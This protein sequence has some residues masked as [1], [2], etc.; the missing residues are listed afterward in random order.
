MPSEGEKFE[1][2]IRRVARAIWNLSPGDGGSEYVGPPNVPTAERQ[3]TDIVGRSVPKTVYLV[4]CTKEKRMQ[5]V[6]DDVEKLVAVRE[7][8]NTQEKVAVQAW[9]VTE[10]EPTGHQRDVGARANVL[11]ESADEFTRRLVDAEGYFA[12]RRTYPFGSAT[13]AFHDDSTTV[14]DDEYVHPTIRDGRRKSHG[15]EQIGRLIESGGVAVLTADFGAGK[16][17]TLR[18]VYRWL[19]DRF[20]NPATAY[21]ARMPIAINLRDHARQEHTDDVLRQHARRIGYP[22]PE[23]LVWAWKHGMA[24]LLLDGFDELPAIPGVD[25]TPAARRHARWE[26]IKIVRDFVRESRT[27][28]GLLLTGRGQY[29][30]TAKERKDACGLK[31]SD[32]ILEL[33]P[34]S[35][36]QVRRYLEKRKLTGDLPDWLP[37]TPLFLSYLVSRDMMPE[38]VAMRGRVNPEAAWDEMLDKLSARE[39]QPAHHFKPEDIRRLLERLAGRGRAAAGG[40]GTVGKADLDQA[41]QAVFGWVKPGDARAV[42]LLQR[43]PGLTHARVAASDTGEAEDDA[44]DRR[45]FVDPFLQDALRGSDLAYFI[46]SPYLP[47]LPDGPAADHRPVNQ[48]LPLFAAQMAAYRVVAMGVAAAGHGQAAKRAAHHYRDPIL[49]ADCLV[50]AALRADVDEFDCDGLT[51]QGGEID[52]CDMSDVRLCHFTLREGVVNNLR[53]A[54]EPPD[55]IRIENCL[56]LKIDG[57]TSRAGLPAWVSSD[58][59]VEAFDSVA[60]A[61]AMLDQNLDPNVRVGLT[62]LKKLYKQRG[63]GRREG[64]LKRGMSLDLRARVDR[65][66]GVLESEGVAYRSK[67]HGAALWHPVAACRE[68]V[69]DILAAPRSSSDP[70]PRRLIELG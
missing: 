55:G 31:D 47:Y 42:A 20:R 30:D 35:P 18:E 16:S 54:T 13:D 67:S 64:A 19:W 15:V 69:D 9:V 29:F 11:V 58:C 32:T 62:V 43:L 38:V 5:K 46:E 12:A 10:H 53:I 28:G 24:D 48:P 39:E 66:V 56:V 7:Y 61:D 59:D 51:L 23:Q 33:E 44:V 21:Q 65:V 26:A 3:E 41:F 49:A 22:N 6:R 14:P 8:L 2:R 4:M 57:V 52:I 1:E 60:T 70:L 25:A 17:L 45:M 50:A 36:D 68:R 34:F 37:R 40:G 63:S 27:R